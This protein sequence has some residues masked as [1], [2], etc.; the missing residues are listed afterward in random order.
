MSTD[1]QLLQKQ[2]VAEA[3]L[4]HVRPDSVL[5]VGTGSTPGAIPGIRHI[6]EPAAVAL[7]RRRAGLITP[8]G[9]AAPAT[10][11]IDTD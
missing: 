1:Q 8:A 3:A 4:A 11:P 2:Q 7:T 9:R 10:F 6:G 5:G